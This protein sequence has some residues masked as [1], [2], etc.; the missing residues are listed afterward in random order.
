MSLPRIQGFGGK[1]GGG[2]SLSIPPDSLRSTAYAKIVDLLCEGEIKGLVDGLKSVYLDG[3]AIENSDG[4]LNFENVSF[5]FRPGTQGQTHIDGFSSVENE[6]SVGVEV[7]TTASVTRNIASQELD[8]V[9]VRISIPQ[10]FETSDKGEV[11]PRTAEIA[12]DLQTAGGGFVPVVTSDKITGITNRE[13]ER[14]YRIA[15][16][17]TGPWDVRVRRISDDDS[18]QL[19]Q[20]R[21]IFESYTEIVDAKLRYPN[22]VLSALRIDSAQFSSIPQRSWLCDLM[23]IQIPSNYDPIARTY[24]GIW[25][26]TFS[27]AWSNNPA[28]VF[29]D[30]VT[31]ERYG[32]GQYLRPE[33]VDIWSLYTIGRY[34]DVLVPDGNGGMEPRFTC[35]LY[36]QTR[37][38]AF[39]VLNN[40]ASIFRSLLFWAGGTLTAIQD[41]PSD[42][43]YLYTA[44]NVIDGQFTYQGASATQQ[45]TVV[46]VTWNDPANHYKQRVEYVEDEALVER[47]G[48]IQTSVVAVG[49]TSQ[50]QAQRVGR[51]LL[52][53]ESMESETVT[54]RAAL[55]GAVGRPGQVLQIA[56]PA[57]AGV[58]LGGRLLGVGA[59]SVKLDAPVVLAAGHTYTLS[60]IAGG[61]VQERAVTSPA[62]TTAEL[63]LAASFE[64]TP[65]VMAVWVLASDLVEPQLVRVLSVVES[66]PNIFEFT[67]LLHNPS[68]YTAIELGTALQIPSTSLLQAPETPQGV[69]VAEQLYTLGAVQVSLAMLSC[70]ASRGA[71]QYEFTY[72]IDG[73]NPIIETRSIPTVELREA[74][75]GLY[76][77]TVVAI[78]S[79]GR[80][81][82]PG[83]GS[84]IVTGL[85]A[86]PAPLDG[87]SLTPAAPNAV[88]SWPAISQVTVRTGGAVAIRYTSATLSSASW[89]TASEI[90]RV[91][92][93]ATSA[94]VNLMG[95]TY[96]AKPID[97]NGL[98]AD[99]AR[100][101]AYAIPGSGG[102]G[103]TMLVY[104]APAS[105]NVTTGLATASTGLCACSLTGGT[106]PYS[107]LWTMTS[108][109][110][111]SILSPT[112][113]ATQ[114]RALGMA[115][116]NVRE[117]TFIC[118]VTDSLGAVVASNTVAVR[119]V[120]DGDAYP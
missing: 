61:T 37:E 72:R 84:G 39:T 89:A 118:T 25:D 54:W 27:I 26:G 6:V 19:K 98:E 114:F 91:P 97:A 92:G 90:E 101:V 78:S 2:G 16:T 73:G 115:F 88:L 52:Y 22:S 24:S 21:T 12:I 58:R 85:G 44:A 32:L 11:G 81:S 105:F 18:N 107:Y 67:G 35:N 94:T 13:Y 7:L 108:G 120:R 86:A 87:L 42:P 17:G 71:T 49:C 74:A 68:K 66:S 28:W 38:E 80:R 82:V 70:V 33:D 55:E 46:L 76:D 9:R 15:L 99:T 5:E 117:A 43:V 100:A 10:L 111:L 57:R 63:G 64:T 36:L 53:S 56:D 77:V 102:G 83:Y 93:A 51:W 20:N 96:L 50:G 79:T 59:S 41:A 69:A 65:P 116:G 62:G 103:G 47:Y 106:S 112:S 110:G 48:I 29:Y 34:C 1:G 109:G 104:A 30:L 95:G 75:S 8:A 3:V 4:S 31:A 23:L 45:H 119:I 60:V 113:S 40:L 14:S